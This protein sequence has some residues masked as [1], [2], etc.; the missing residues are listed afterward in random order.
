M[1]HHCV[2]EAWRHWR[3]RQRPCMA[4]RWRNGEQRGRQRWLPRDL[5]PD[6]RRKDHGNRKGSGVAKPE[7]ESRDADGASS[8]SRRRRSLLL[9]QGRT[10]ISAQGQPGS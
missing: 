8:E 7:Q 5:A 3:Q 4:G 2:M 10:G 6:T 1:R 9:R